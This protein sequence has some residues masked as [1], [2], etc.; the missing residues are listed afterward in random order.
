MGIPSKDYPDVVDIHTHVF[1]ARYLPLEGIFL[2]HLGKSSAFKRWLARTVAT[3]LEQATGSSYSRE[4]VAAGRGFAGDDAAD[5]IWKC[6][7]SEL[8]ARTRGHVEAAGNSRSDR[9]YAA[10]R[11]EE[12][13]LVMALLEGQ[14]ML[15]ASGDDPEHPS[16]EDPSHRLDIDRIL[17]GVRP[18]RRATLERVLNS[19]TFSGFG[20]VVKW[21]VKKLWKLF[22]TIA[23]WWETADDFLM[24]FARML[25]AEKDVLAA[26]IRSYDDDQHVRLLVHHMMDM[27][28][29]YD[30]PDAPRYLFAEQ[31]ERMRKLAGDNKHRLVGFTAFDPRR[32][33]VWTMPTGFTGVKFYPGMG[34]RPWDN[35]P[36]IQ[37]RVAAFLRACAQ[38][39]VPVFA[40]CTP[41]GFQSQPGS[42][43]NAHPKY[44][45]AALEQPGLRD[46]RLCLGHAG[47]G[48]MQNDDL[49]SYGWYAT[50]PEEWADRDNFARISVELCTNFLNV[51][52]ELG[53]LHEL[54]TDR[55]S[56]LAFE[57][58]F[59]P[60]WKSV[61]PLPFATKC[62]FGSDH[63]MPLMINRAADLLTYFKDL[64]AR[65]SLDGFA[66][67]CAGNARTYLRLTA[68]S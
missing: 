55:K 30:P 39:D 59:V 32:Q 16:A 19:G 26:L 51:Y 14:A 8:E 68:T 47:G 9:E 40:H 24:F 66:A 33:D 11:L 56:R 2:S 6:V 23:G 46:L 35:T 62:M 20:A 17:A 13:P 3:V 15:T 50:T 37:P 48:K 38:S 58:N 31:E 34:Y 22:D 53:H 25:M 61:G 67:F 63:H 12:D 10:D 60:A 44:W 41:R 43:K 36:D 18:T 1:N 54:L 57:A 27:Q 7:E 42:G 29:A 52:C 28:Y 49:L 65:E 5:E 21:L 64:F 45:R 4:A